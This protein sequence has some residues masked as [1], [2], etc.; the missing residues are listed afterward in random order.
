MT[1]RMTRKQTAAY[2]RERGIPIGD[3]TLDKLCMP[4]AD[5]GPPVAAWWGRRPL[6]NP[7]KALAWAEARMRV[8]QTC[9]SRASKPRLS[10]EVHS[11]CDQHSKED[12][13]G[14][15]LGGHENASDVT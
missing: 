8:G 12:E 2:L 13:R 14:G 9:V 15:A 6:Y 1:E 11:D 4:S 3:S 5:E 7:K 10:Q